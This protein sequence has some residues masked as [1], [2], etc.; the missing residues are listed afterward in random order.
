M[1]VPWP[2]ER[3]IACLERGDL[4]KAH[5][6]PESVGGQLV[7]PFECRGCNGRA[8]H[9][10]ESAL[11]AEPGVRY[12]T[13]ILGGQLG[14]LATRIRA[15]APFVSTDDG[16]RIRAI[17]RDDGYRIQDSVQDDGSLVKD[18]KRAESDIRTSLSKRGATPNQIAG[19][20]RRVGDAP[21]GELVDLGFGMSARRGGTS[22]FAPDLAGGNLVRNEC[23]LAIGYRFLALAVGSAIYHPSLNGVRQALLGNG[24]G[25]GWR[26]EWLHV[27][28]PHEPWHGLAVKQLEPHV[29]VQVR[30]FAQLAWEVHFEI[31]RAPAP[32]TRLQYVLELS[33]PPKEHF[34]SLLSSDRD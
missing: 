1:F 19:A 15:R 24:P 32:S 3:C 7:A 5:V 31:I 12:A 28:R 26:V 10:F 33:S 9:A 8:G 27:R 2:A 6:I 16:R 14:D 17:R 20:L 11:K 4:T 18:P 29:V 34:G 30:L 13:E 25:S 21:I 23:F 22:S